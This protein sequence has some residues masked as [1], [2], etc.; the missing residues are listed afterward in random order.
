MTFN[1]PREH[2]SVRTEQLWLTI[3]N[4]FNEEKLLIVYQLKDLGIKFGFS[5]FWLLWKLANSSCSQWM[6][7]WP[8]FEIASSIW[9]ALFPKEHFK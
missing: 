3:I 9:K 6:A 8:I 2:C 5:K 7:P 4:I 1:D